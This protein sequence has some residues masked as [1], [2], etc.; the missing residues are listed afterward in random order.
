MTKKK[1]VTRVLDQ[2]EAKTVPGMLFDSARLYPTKDV[3][4]YRRDGADGAVFPLYLYILF[5][6][7]I[8]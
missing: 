6:C 2:P 4:R 3:F 8:L 5:I 7:D 1:S